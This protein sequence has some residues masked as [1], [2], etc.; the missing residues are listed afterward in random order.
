MSPRPM[1]F[2]VENRRNDGC[3][4]ITFDWSSSVSLPETSSTRWITNITSGRPASYS[5]K[6]ERR[7]DL[8]RA[9][10][11]AL[12]ELGHLL[13][14]LQHDRVL[15][16]EIDAADV[17]VEVDADARPVEARRDLLDVRRLAGAVVALDHHAAV[18]LEAGEDGERH[19]AVE[20]IVGIEVGNVLVRLGEGRHLEIGVDAEH[21]PHRKL[22]VRKTGQLGFG[23]RAGIARASSRAFEEMR[24]FRNWRGGAAGLRPGPLASDS[25]RLG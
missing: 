20:Q 5:S 12:A 11:D 10:Q 1:V 2:V 4:R 22:H 9:R 15:A 23:T 14:V 17:A 21:L 6:H 8:Q 18:V 19:V 7:V 25:Y 24:G 13:A 3:G 16:D